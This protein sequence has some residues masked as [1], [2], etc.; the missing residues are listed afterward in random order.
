MIPTWIV[1]FPAAEPDRL[2]VGILKSTYTDK[3]LVSVDGESLFGELAILRWMAKDGWRGVWADTFHGR[4]FW[5]N[6]PH[7]STPTEPPSHVRSVY[8][9]IAGLKGGPGGCF[10]AICWKAGRIVWLEYK[11]PGDN[12]NKNEPAWIAAALQ[13]GVLL[14]DLIFVGDKGR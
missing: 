3:P 7:L 4:K 11:G 6:M 9:E 14:S 5:D 12:P 1:N 8:Q 13:F 10:D 2:P